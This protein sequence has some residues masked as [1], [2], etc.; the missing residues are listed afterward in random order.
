MD[1]ERIDLGNGSSLTLDKDALAY[2]VEAGN[3][4][5]EIAQLWLKPGYLAQKLKPKLPH[6]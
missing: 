6:A 1:E 2:H 3:I 5:A 4:P